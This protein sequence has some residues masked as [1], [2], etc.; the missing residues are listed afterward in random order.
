MLFTDRRSAPTE[1][2]K[3]IGKGFPGGPVVENLLSVWGTQVGSLVGELI[4]HIP[5]G[6]H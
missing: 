5:Q 6:S 2:V 1:L 4:S 3:N